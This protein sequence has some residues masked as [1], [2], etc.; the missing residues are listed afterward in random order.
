MVYKLKRGYAFALYTLLQGYAFKT[1]FIL[2]RIEVVFD[3]FN[4]KYMKQYGEISK[5][6]P[7]QAFGE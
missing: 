4:C 6:S 2:F 7:K 5:I 1:N 3:H